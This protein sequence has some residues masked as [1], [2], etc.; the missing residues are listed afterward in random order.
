[1]D[2]LFCK[3][4]N[5]GREAHVRAVGSGKAVFARSSEARVGRRVFSLDNRLHGSREGFTNLSSHG[6]PAGRKTR[7]S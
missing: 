7:K 6:L 2:V 5:H 3:G 4:R 1:M